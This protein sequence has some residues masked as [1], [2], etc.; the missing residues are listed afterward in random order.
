MLD[1]LCS[2]PVKYSSKF[3][4]SFSD[5]FATANVAAGTGGVDASVGFETTR[6]ENVGPGIPD[7]LFF[8]SFFVNA[9]TSSM[10]SF[11][12]SHVDLC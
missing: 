12:P 10:Y 4:L 9:K 6:P 8:F 1:T 7:S 3:L 11:R 2:P 5:D